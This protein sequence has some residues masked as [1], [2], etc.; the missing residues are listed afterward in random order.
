MSKR[1]IATMV[2][3]ALS[4]I[5]ATGFAVAETI[6]RFQCSIIDTP[7]IEKIDRPDHYLLNLQ[8]SCFA[9]DGLLKDDVH[10]ASS[11]TEVDGAK[12]TFLRGGGLHRSAGGL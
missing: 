1:F 11:V 9:T 3:S 5:G 12:L 10:T 2:C 4:L 6:G 7:G 8:Y